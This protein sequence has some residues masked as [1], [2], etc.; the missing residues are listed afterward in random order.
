MSLSG[1]ETQEAIGT[2]HGIGE[3]GDRA[4][5]QLHETLCVSPVGVRWERILRRHKPELQGLLAVDL[6][7]RAHAA[8]A[9]VRLAAARS[10]RALG[11][12]TIL[13]VSRV[14]DGLS[15]RASVELQ[16]DIQGMRDELALAR[17]HSL[18]ELLAPYGRTA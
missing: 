7:L 1:C 17:G 11:D 2:M 15:R 16:R 6:V 10:E 4:T 14:L 3:D 5:R 12:D 13:S 9:L 18:D 8:D